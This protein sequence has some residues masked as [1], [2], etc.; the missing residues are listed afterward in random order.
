MTHP[1]LLALDAGGSKVDAVLLTRGGHVLGAA[2]VA[3]PLDRYADGGDRDEEV[4]LG[5][6]VA[7]IDAVCA[8]AGLDP[9]SVPIADVGVYCLAGADLPA[10]DRRISKALKRRG[11]TAEDIVRNDTFAVLRAGTD[12]DWGVAVVCGYGMNCSGVAPDGRVLR[13]PAVGRI[14]GDWGGGSDIGALALWHALRARDGR[15]ASTVLA[16]LVAE[17]FGKRGPR[18]VMEAIYFGRLSEQRLVE[19]A[20]IVFRA[21]AQGDE[22]ARSIVDRQADEVVT[23]AGA[24]IRRLRLTKLDVDVVLGGGIFRTTDPGFLE[25]IDSGLRNI[26]PSVR[27]GALD[28]PPVVG[29]ALLG[30]DRLGAGTRAMR[31][32]REHLTHPRLTS[33]PGLSASER[34]EG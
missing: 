27:I 26:A 24:A 13:F 14:S 29:A 23:M 12:R 34:A 8:E 19:L 22:I 28:G 9:G 10:D 11:W 6:A 32:V 15:G 7:A 31:R 16:D 20:P 30:L 25:R 4:R 17:H 21:A 18:H 33:N 3:V 5:T 1:A 2:R